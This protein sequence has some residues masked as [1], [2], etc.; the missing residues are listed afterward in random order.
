MITPTTTAIEYGCQCDCGNHAA[1][2]LTPLALLV[3]RDGHELR[4]CTRCVLSTDTS[5][6]LLVSTQMPADVFVE[7][8][9]LG[10]FMVLGYLADQSLPIES[11]YRATLLKVM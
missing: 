2:H 5:L 11:D 6:A 8:D 4:V 10:A 1:T 3:S 7:F 9:A